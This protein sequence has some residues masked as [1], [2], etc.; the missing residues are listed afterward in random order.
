M[1]SAKRNKRKPSMESA[2]VLR[3]FDEVKGEA[4][5]IERP[6]MFTWI[7]IYTSWRGRFWRTRIAEL[8]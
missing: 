7:P 4:A 2:E 6:T 8:R 5:K 3:L 1:Q